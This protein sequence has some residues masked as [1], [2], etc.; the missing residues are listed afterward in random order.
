MNTKN[1]DH[2]AFVED[3]RRRNEDKM[4]EVERSSVAK[5]TEMEERVRRACGEAKKR[6]E[7]ERRR[8]EEETN[9]LKQTHV[10]IMQ[11]CF[12][13]QYNNFFC[14]QCRDIDMG[15]KGED[16]AAASLC[17]SFCLN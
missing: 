13:I 17:F 8:Q 6:V 2:D 14:P 7:E 15:C 16:S 10:S 4:A 9:Q 3:L 5:W 1:E 12:S 11:A